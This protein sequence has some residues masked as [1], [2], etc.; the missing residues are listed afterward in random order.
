MSSMFERYREVSKRTSG[1]VLIVCVV[2]L[3]LFQLTFSAEAQANDVITVRE[4][5]EAMPFAPGSIVIPMDEKQNDS[6]L[7][8]GFMHALLRNNTIC[9]RL[10]GPPGSLIRTEAFPDGV[11]YVGGPIMIQEYNQTLLESIKTM[12]PSVTVHNETETF[13]SRTVYKL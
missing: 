9:Y 6:I 10:I 4:R 5:Y 11:D 13:I 1:M 2:L 12:F 8:F 7:S 3:F